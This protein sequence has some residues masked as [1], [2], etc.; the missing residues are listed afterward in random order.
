[1]EKPKQLDMLLPMSKCAEV[2]FRNVLT[3]LTGMIRRT[4]LVCFRQVLGTFLVLAAD[5]GMKEN[6]YAS[7][8]HQDCSLREELSFSYHEKNADSYQ[9][10]VLAER[11]SA[12]S[13]H[14]RQTIGQQAVLNG[15]QNPLCVRWFSQVTSS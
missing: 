6:S 5:R 1:M 11:A 2:F 15:K 8:L 13:S 12:V 4:K 7:S 3:S 9:V 10:S 14:H